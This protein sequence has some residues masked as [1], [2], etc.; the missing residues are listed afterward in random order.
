MTG[1]KRNAKKSDQE[2]VRRHTAELLQEL[3]RCL[4][5]SSFAVGD[6]VIAHMDIAG[7]PGYEIIHGCLRE[8]VNHLMGRVTQ[9]V[10]K[11]YV[12]EKINRS[13]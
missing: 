6:W 2:S 4:R 3:L 8:S 11:E 12:Q 7:Q 5:E 13:Y 9:I 10:L 1:K